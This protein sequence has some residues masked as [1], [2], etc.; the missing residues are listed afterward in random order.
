MLGVPVT[1]LDAAS[2]PDHLAGSVLEGFSILPMIP[3]LLLST[4]FILLIDARVFAHA[5]AFPTGVFHPP[6]P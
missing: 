4:V 5:P 3:H 6:V 1:L 2:T